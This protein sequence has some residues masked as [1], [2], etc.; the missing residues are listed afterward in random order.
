M[1]GQRAA[2]PCLVQEWYAGVDG[3]LFFFVPLTIVVSGGQGENVIV[4]GLLAI[5]DSG[6]LLPCGHGRSLPRVVPHYALRVPD[7]MQTVKTT[8]ADAVMVVVVVVV[9]NGHVASE[10]NES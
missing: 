4:F 7:Q 1:N 10:F 6:L 5:V 2:S 3:F 8:G 9:D